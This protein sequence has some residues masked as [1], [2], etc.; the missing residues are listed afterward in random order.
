LCVGNNGNIAVNAKLCISLCDVSNTLIIKR[1]LCGFGF[2]LA[3]II[4]NVIIFVRFIVSG[5]EKFI[6]A[7]NDFVCGNSA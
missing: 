4:G 7:E 2:K 5:E 6:I 3:V 1:K